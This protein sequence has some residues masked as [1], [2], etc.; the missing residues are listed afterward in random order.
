MSPPLLSNSLVKKQEGNRALSQ[1]ACPW[2]GSGHLAF[3]HSRS[4]LNPLPLL[5]FRRL[6]AVPSHRQLQGSRM[7]LIMFHGPK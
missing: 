6:Q 2:L 7:T 5:T 3:S 1:G 4:H